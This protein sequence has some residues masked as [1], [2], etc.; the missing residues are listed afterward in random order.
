MGPGG[1]DGRSLMGRSGERGAMTRGAMSVPTPAVRLAVAPADVR[2][3]FAAAAVPVGDDVIGRLRGACAEVDTGRDTLVESGRDWWPLAVRW[4]LGGEVPAVAS[5]VARPASASEVA[6]VL[7]ICHDARVPATVMGGRSGVCGNSV[8]VFG[9]V[10]I[11][12][13]GL[14]GVVAVDDES[15]LVDVR[16]GTFGDVFEAGLRE[17]QGLTLGHWPQSIA[18]STVGGWLACRWAGQYSTR[19]GKIEDMVVGLEV[20][21]ADGR[22]IRTGGTAPRA[23]T[24]P[25]L[26]QLFV[27]GEGTLGVITEARLR[28]HPLPAAERRAAFGFAVLRGRAGRVPADTAPGCHARRTATV[29][30]GR[31]AGGRSP[32]PRPTC[33]SSWTRVSPA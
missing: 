17:E 12:L 22:L 1:P 23:A 18:L 33:S 32:T 25:D 5:A 15:L 20:A 4:A 26:T 27:G 13:T 19:Y 14:G 8:P 7:A 11:D 29:R 3:R 2:V 9:G 6:A 31:V 21:L 30:Q 10:L 24:G 28:A 16:A